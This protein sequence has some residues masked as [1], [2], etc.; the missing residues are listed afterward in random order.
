M[1]YK[2]NYIDP[3]HK[4]WTRETSLT[5]ASEMSEIFIDQNQSLSFIWFLTMCK[6]LWLLQAGHLQS[7]PEII[8]VVCYKSAIFMMAKWKRGSLSSA[9]FWDVVSFVDWLE[10]VLLSEQQ[11]L[12]L[13]SLTHVLGPFTCNPWVPMACPLLKHACTMNIHPLKFLR[14]LYLHAIGQKI[15]SICVFS[16]PTP[17]P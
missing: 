13:L 7:S 5:H 3:P 17:S 12:G 16:F 8:F 11:F 4:K 10:G 1:F 6:S 14:A 9:V 2:K 15:H